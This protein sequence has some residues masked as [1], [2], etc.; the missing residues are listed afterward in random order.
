MKHQL[1]RNSNQNILYLEKYDEREPF[2]KVSVKFE[3]KDKFICIHGDS[4]KD[5][6]KLHLAGKSLRECNENDHLD[7][8]RCY[9]VHD[10]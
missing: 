6:L 4:L 3:G 10:M 7:F 5:C 9:E 8:W 1:M 2:W